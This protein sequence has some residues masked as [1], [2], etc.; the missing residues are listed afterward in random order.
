MRSFY[1]TSRTA[2]RGL[3]RNLMRSVLTCIGIVIGI[4]AVIAQMEIG[5]GT[6]EAVRQTIATLGANFIQVEAGSNSTSG[7]HMGTGTCLTLTPQ[8][9]DAILRECGTVR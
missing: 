7:V 9:C 1:R 5:Q 4:A 2:V 3:R 8:D 6:A